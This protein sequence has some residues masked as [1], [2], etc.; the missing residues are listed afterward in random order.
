M[1]K[2]LLLGSLLLICLIAEAQRYKSTESYIRF[3]SEAPLENIDAINESSSAMID[4]GDQTLV[5]VVPIKEFR[6]RK[7]L[8]QQH[9]NENYLESDKY[10]KA[11]FEGSIQGWDG[12]NGDFEAVAL[13]TLEM[14]GVTQQ[15]QVEGQ[16]NKDENGL[17]L[18]TVFEVQLEDYKIKIPK[19]VFYKIAE[20]VEVTAKFTF[21]PYEKN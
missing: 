7:K 10:P 4:A 6:F 11:V 1:K 16:L 15:V 13:G 17:V 19:A 21:E 3:F 2:S 9:F 14:H 5:I 12:T 8:M 20:V 18:T